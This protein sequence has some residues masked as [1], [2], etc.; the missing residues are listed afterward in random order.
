[1][2]LQP[3][4]LESLKVTVATAGVICRHSQRRFPHRTAHPPPSKVCTACTPKAPKGNAV[5]GDYELEFTLNGGAFDHPGGGLIVR[6]E[7]RAPLPHCSAVRCFRYASRTLGMQVVQGF[8]PL[9]CFA[10]HGVLS[11]GYAVHHGH[12]HVLGC[13]GR[14]SP[15]RRPLLLGR[16]WH[17]PMVRRA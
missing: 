8:P 16:E 7:V 1:M 10:G 9:L 13:V 12:A 14:L 4:R 2:D 5:A 11:D 15:L 17:E 3:R 6:F